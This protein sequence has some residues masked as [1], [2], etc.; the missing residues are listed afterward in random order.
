MADPAFAPVARLYQSGQ[1]AL[2]EAECR[3]LLAANPRHPDASHLLGVLL[4]QS[5][6]TPEALTCLDSA[7]TARPG[8]LDAQQ[9]F[10]TALAMSGDFTRAMTCFE[11]VARA[12]PA[13]LQALYNLGLTLSKLGRHEEARKTFAK[14]LSRDARNVGAWMGQGAA[15]A[16]LGRFADAA[17]SFAKA[18][19]LAPNQPEI[20]EN[21]ALAY[22]DGSEPTKAQAA[23][24]KLPQQIVGD[25]P[26]ALLLHARC[27]KNLGRLDNAE[28]TLRQLLDRAPDYNEARISLGALLCETARYQAAEHELRRALSVSPD[29]LEALYNLG[30]SLH[31]ME[32]YREAIDCYRHILQRMPSDLRSRISL[33]SALLESELWEEA[34]QVLE[35]AAQ[36]FP[37]SLEAVFNYALCLQALGRTDDAIRDFRNILAKWPDEVRAL[38]SLAVTLKDRGEPEQA[39]I[40][41]RQALALK[42]DDAELRWNLCMAL[43]QSG[44]LEEG[45]ALFSCR[46]QTRHFAGTARY[47]S[48]LGWDGDPRSLAGKRVLVWGEQGIG[49]ELCFA[50]AFGEIL[51]FT[52]NVVLEC[53]P[54]LLALFQRSFPNLEVRARDGA[55]VAAPD[56]DMQIPAGDLFRFFRGH[57]DSFPGHASYLSCDISASARWADWLAGLGPGRKIGVSWKT[58]LMTRKRMKYHFH[59]LSDWMPILQQRNCVFINLQP[60]ISETELNDLSKR[61]GIRLHQPPGLDLFNDLDGVASLLGALDLVLSSGNAVAFLAGALGRTVWMFH[62]SHGHWDCLGTQGY[63][64]IPSVRLFSKQVDEGWWPAIEAVALEL[65]RSAG[66]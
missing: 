17:D 62:V 16:A 29:S 41:Y 23:L 6:R 65:S 27:E 10:G 33:G 7:V 15:L 60:G 25:R 3:R 18:D 58:T 39:V 2:A 9:V 38:H 61:L 46:W 21:L 32:S 1:H 35:P 49:D 51:P 57:I 40:L 11:K 14:L 37:D 4:L 26:R 19:A 24:D 28:T 56:F 5:N 55:S 22:L 54:K 43:L 44:R 47:E 63:P 53:A 34:L 13:N 64:W 45:W 30:L 12:Q 36:E 8:N 42:P 50:S 59:D 48:L 31:R 20:I 52:S 66:S